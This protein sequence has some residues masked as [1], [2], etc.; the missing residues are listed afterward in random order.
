MD[1]LPDDYATWEVP[2][3]PID[4]KHLGRT[5]EAIIRVNSQSGKGGVAYVMDAEHGLDLPRASQVEFLQAGPGSH[6]SQRHRDQ[7][8]RAVGC[9]RQHLLARRRQDP[10]HLERGCFWW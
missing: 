10:A 5:Y 3:L 1:A 2:Y 8:G 6:R 9:L 4:P 7:A